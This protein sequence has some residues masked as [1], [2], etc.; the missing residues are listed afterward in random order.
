M[1]DQNSSSSLP[2]AGG[3]NFRDLGGNLAIDGRKVKHGLLFRSGALNQLTP[4]DLHYLSEL[5][6]T[7]IL[8]YRD[9]DEIDKRPD[10]LWQ[11]V[12]YN[13]QPANCTGAGLGVNLEYLSNE[14]LD[15]VDCREFMLYL[16]RTLPFA[17][18]AYRRLAQL[19]ESDNP[20]G[21]V[22]HC[23]VG[24]DRTGVGSALVLLALGADQATVIEDYLLTQPH[25]EPFRQKMYD[26]VSAKLSEQNMAKLSYVL[27]AREEFIATALE[28]IHE[29]YGSFDHW[30]QEEYGLDREKR[31]ALQQ[32]YLEE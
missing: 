14:T 25:L 27:S 20:G 9:N 23:A 5:P 6:V 10:L 31:Q 29:R 2:I 4:Q 18:P 17:N 11:G 7:Q 8:D 16:Y 22:Q 28:S 15:P 30:L 32:R 1:A 19:L 3:V 24:K 26:V 13:H 21:L 12:N